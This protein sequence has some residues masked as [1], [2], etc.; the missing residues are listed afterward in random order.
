M[1]LKMTEESIKAYIN[2]N[3]TEDQID[4]EVDEAIP[5]FLDEDW[6]EEYSDEFEAYQ[7]T[8]R[9]EAESQVRMGIE[10]EILT[11]LGIEYFEFEKAM[12]KTISQIICDIFPKLD[13]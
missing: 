3:Y 4:S 5:D 2:T 10:N 9:G 13:T 1:E 6:E 8:G 12:G 7:E 11:K